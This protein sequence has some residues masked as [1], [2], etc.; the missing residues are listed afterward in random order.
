M[1]TLYPLD[2]ALTGKEY[3]DAFLGKSL[4]EQSFSFEAVIGTEK[5]ENGNEVDVAQTVHVVSIDFVDRG[6]ELF[7]ASFVNPSYRDLF[8]RYS[9]YKF[10]SPSLKNYLPDSAAFITALEYISNLSGT[11]VSGNSVRIS[12]GVGVEDGSSSPAK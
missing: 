7:S 11:V 12:V 10:L 8:H 9:I 4:G 1:I 6:D 2:S 5:D 3:K